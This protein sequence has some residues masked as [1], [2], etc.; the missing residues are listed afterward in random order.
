M[1]K[2]S[3]TIQ[4]NKAATIPVSI[5]G[6]PANLAD[7]A[8]ANISY[9]FD[10]TGFVFTIETR[11]I[12]QY[13]PSGTSSYSTA[14]LTLPAQSIDGVVSA[15]NTIGIGVFFAVGNLI[16]TYNNNYVFGTLSV[17]PPSGVYI[18][19]NNQTTANP[20]FSTMNF[21]EGFFIDPYSAGDGYN[22]YLT[23][24]FTLIDL[25]A[26]PFGSATSYVQVYKDYLLVYSS[27]S[28][29]WAYS[30][31]PSGDAFYTVIWRDAP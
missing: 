10:F 15:L 3:I 23:H 14:T 12:L 29:G 8:N 11:L 2:I 20:L 26:N 4:N 27:N 18:Y 13:K 25:S 30:D 5:L 1:E 21:T 17:L 19:L 31:T 9:S 16:Q 6:N 22:G 24:N 28:I 7:I